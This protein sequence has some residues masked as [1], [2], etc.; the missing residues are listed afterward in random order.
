MSKKNKFKKMTI[1]T[2]F[3]QRKSK[4]LSL[5]FIATLLGQDVKYLSDKSNS[6]IEYRA[7]VRKLE[8]KTYFM[9]GYGSLMNE[10]DVPRTIPNY[11]SFKTGFIQGWERIFNM[12]SSDTGSYL[13][14]R[15]TN[16]ETPMIVSVI[17]VKADMMPSIIMRERNYRF[18]DVE[19]A[20]TDE[21]G[22]VA[23][24]YDEGLTTNA[25]MVIGNYES[26]VALEPQLNYLHLCLAGTMDLGGLAGIQ[27]FL[28]TTF[29]YRGGL[30]EWF[31]KVDL[32]EL[33]MKH[34]YLKR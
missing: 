19:V 20:V 32:L 30:T 31:K 24:I 11:E 25:K 26:Y 8:D 15:P 17:E 21:E 3:E 29:T 10:T 16:S 2:T 22:E 18:I 4:W 34:C 6:I 23:E 5:E 12:G 7:K 28:D 27:N 14:A 9:V 1:P 13:N 33:M